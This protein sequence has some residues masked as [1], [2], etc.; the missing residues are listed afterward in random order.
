MNRHLLR[1]AIV[2]PLTLFGLW[3]CNGHPLGTPTPRPEQQTDQYHEANPVREV[4]ILFVIDNSP[5]MKEEQDRLRDNF[6]VFMDELD[7][8]TGGRPDVHVGVVSSDLGSGVNGQDNCS[9]AGG[10]R[11]VLQ[12]G[13]GCGLDPNSRF[14]VSNDR[15]ARNNFTGDIRT[16]FSCMANLGDR[17]CGFEHQLE[18]AR[19]ALDAKVTPEN[20]GFL[21]DNAYLAII[22][23]TDEDDCSA[24]PQS[25]IFG[26][27]IGD[28]AHSMRCSVYGHVCKGQQPPF[29]EFSAPFSDCQPADDGKLIRVSAIVDAIRGMKKNPAEQ[30]LVSGIFGWPND[31]ASAT[32]RYSRYVRPGVSSVDTAYACTATDTGATA[33]L[34]VNQFV[35]SFGKNG[36]PLS[37]CQDNFREAMKLIGQR[38]SQIFE[39]P[40]LHAPA[41]DTSADPGMQADCQVVDSIPRQGGFETVALPRCSGDKTP[42]W[43][44][45]PDARCDPTGGL[46]MEVDRGGQLPPP[47]TQQ[48]I[49]CLTCAS[50]DDPRCR[51]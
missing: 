44:L 36:I 47:G 31:A 43:R 28:T 16:V 8:I 41:V 35:K 45:V 17:G 6:P 11:A 14:L 30:I 10:D 40:C 27:T 26:E 46:K 1:A 24:D 39:P 33:A 15:G 3:A 4:D 21:R 34:R 23:L 51:R 22:V 2:T 5:S 13:T 25:T 50:P 18:A 32:Y 49:K 48:S 12:V 42:C 38:L 20:A 7:Q 29:S 37:I 9:R 19:R